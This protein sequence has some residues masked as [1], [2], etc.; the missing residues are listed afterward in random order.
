M[1]E[2][3]LLWK[4]TH[5]VRECTDL[6]VFNVGHEGGYVPLGFKLEFLHFLE[7]L[8][9]GCHLDTIVDLKV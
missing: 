4:C 9:S 7:E 8:W 3:V 1:L 2:G 5:L 6:L